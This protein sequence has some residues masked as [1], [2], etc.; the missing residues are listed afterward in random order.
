[1]SSPLAKRSIQTKTSDDQ[2]KSW[3]YIFLVATSSSTHKRIKMGFPVDGSDWLGAVVWIVVFFIQIGGQFAS[4]SGVNTRAIFRMYSAKI[5]GAPPTW[6]FGPVW[7]A[8]YTLLG[9]GTWLGWRSTDYRVNN[10][11]EYDLFILFAI[12][13]ALF[14]KFWTPLFT[15]AMMFTL[16]LFDLLLCIGTNIA[17]IVFASRQELWVTVAFFAA[18]LAW[19]LFAAYLNARF[20]PF[21]RFVSARIN[22]MRCCNAQ[23]Y[24]E[25]LNGSVKPATARE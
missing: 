25:C 22:A 7:F 6:V 20:I 19:L 12:L 15:G 13:H 10:K 8:L 16:A 24:A 21:Q 9:V 5:S 1:M 2:T 3:R 17:V 23:F 4:A 11:S 18:E 14:L